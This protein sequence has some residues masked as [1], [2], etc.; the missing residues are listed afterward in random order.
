MLRRERLRLLSPA[1]PQVILRLVAQFGGAG[2][3]SG[4]DIGLPGVHSMGDGSRSD[5]ARDHRVVV[6]LGELA[7]LRPC[8]SNI[9]Q[10]L[11]DEP[12]RCGAHQ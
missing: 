6:R 5:C 12:I 8:G 4:P 10:V 9:I 1:Q 3:Q 11:V 7:L 2:I